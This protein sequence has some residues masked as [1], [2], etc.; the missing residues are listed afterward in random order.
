MKDRSISWMES[1]ITEV[2]GC[3]PTIT[4]Y[5]ALSA[6]VLQDVRSI[7]E[8]HRLDIAVENLLSRQIIKRF[9]DENNYTTYCMA[10]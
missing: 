7:D 8:Q 6:N 3:N 4:T 10:A 5:L 9:K 2:L 1:K